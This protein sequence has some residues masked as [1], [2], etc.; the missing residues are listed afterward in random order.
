MQSEQSLDPRPLREG[1][2][3]LDFAT[4]IWWRGRMGFYIRKSV[5]AGPFRFNLSKSGLGISVGVKGFR[6]GTGPRGNYV[7]MGRG[8]LYYRASLGGGHSRSN[9]QPV[10][11]PPPPEP[12]TYHQASLQDVESGNLMEMVPSNGSA[13][14]EQINE[15][16]A[17][18][19]V[20]PWVLVLGLLITLFLASQPQTENLTVGCFFAAI[21]AAAV[22]SY[23]DHQRKTVVI[24]YDLEE[25]SLQA[26]EALANA[27]DRVSRV[28]RIWN[29]EKS[30]RTSDWKR[31]AGAGVLIDRKTVQLGYRLPAVVKTNVSVPSITGGRQA[32]YF[33][34]DVVLVMEGQRAGAITYNQFN[35][36]WHDTVFI[37]SDGVPNDAQVV[38]HTWRY[39]NRDG[40]PDRR[41]N[42]NRQ[43]P[44]VR[45][46]EM[47]LT[48]PGGFNKVLQISKSEDRADFNSALTQLRRVIRDLEQLALPVPASTASA[49]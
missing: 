10:R 6:L 42:N 5:S 20:W 46:Q 40:G 19:R 33:F 24:L 47:A 3:W 43:I 26:F 13:V 21:A 32:I 14:L 8:G 27:L 25:G 15:K 48:G 41:F 22:A 37:E 28:Q 31:N 38:G 23:M 45:Y 39:V 29:I 36:Q 49:G 11:R 2:H 34:P 9:A 30:G 4:S 16:M 12:Q 1:I 44:K 18:H 7:H 17:L 35:V